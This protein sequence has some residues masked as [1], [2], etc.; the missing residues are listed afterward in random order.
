MFIISGG[1][2]DNGTIRLNS[3]DA[4]GSSLMVGTIEICLNSSWGTICDD[5]WVTSNAKVA[6]RQL[7]FSDRGISYMSTHRYTHP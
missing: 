6:C 1:C 7:G 4:S 5:S 2:K 3:N